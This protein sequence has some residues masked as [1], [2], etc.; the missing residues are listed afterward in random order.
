MDTLPRMSA[1]TVAVAA[2][3]SWSVRMRAFSEAA[4]LFTICASL[5]GFIQFGTSGL[6]D[7]D[8]YYHT[9]MGWLIRQQGLTP[10]FVWLP[11]TILNRHAFYDHHL[12]YH[13]YLS[14]FTG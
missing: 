10:S 3:P 9:K 11:M 5:F 12:L 4:V 6:V 1:N 14:F 2:R 13:V 7:N 8:A